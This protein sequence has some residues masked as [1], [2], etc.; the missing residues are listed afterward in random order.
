LQSKIPFGP[1]IALAAIIWVLG[2]Y[3]WWDAYTNWVTGAAGY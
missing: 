3:G 1:Y 2:G